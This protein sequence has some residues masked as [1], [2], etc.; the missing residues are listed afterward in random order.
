VKTTPNLAAKNMKFDEFMKRYTLG[1]FELIQAYCGWAESQAKNQTDLLL[2]GLGPIFLIGLVLW[3][4]PV[5]LGKTLALV[6]LA[7]ALYV[8]FV[9][10]R[11][12]AGRG[13]K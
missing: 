12:Y 8:A 10:L 9:I 4:L 3:L 1:F 5:W 7:P 11:A 2:L 6:L 13:R